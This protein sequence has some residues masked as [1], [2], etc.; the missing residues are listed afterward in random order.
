M[1]GATI[2]RELGTLT[3]MLRLAY[4]NGKVFR[5]PLFRKPKEGAPRQGFF[6]ADQYQAVRRRLPEDLQVAVTIAYTYGWRMQN[7]V[8]TLQRRQL[9]LETGT[10]RLEPG[11]TKNDE[12]RVAYLTPELKA[13]LVAQVA[14]VEALQR[15]RGQIIPFPSRIWARGAGRVGVA[16]TSAKGGLQP[17]RRRACPG[18][19]GMISGAR[20]CG[21]WSTRVSGAGG[22]EDHR[23]Q[24]AGR[25]RPLP[26][27]Q[28]W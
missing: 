21:T 6:E 8:L 27:R 2:R 15:R 22:D 23:P 16:E 19:T 5:L 18:C 9:D 3:R 25:V 24:D 1:V 28:P 7:E 12:G 11:S 4:Q 10:L 26:H 20:R 13:L 17:A 14:R